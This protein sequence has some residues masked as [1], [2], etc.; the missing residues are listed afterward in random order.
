[1]LC[2]V[3]SLIT[4]HNPPGRIT[5]ALLYMYVPADIGKSIQLPRGL[6]QHWQAIDSQC[7]N[8]WIRVPAFGPFKNHVDSQACHEA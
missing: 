1:M 8:E 5:R 6:N 4:H 7:E 2:S 3:S